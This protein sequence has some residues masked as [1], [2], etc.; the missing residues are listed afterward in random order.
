MGNSIKHIFQD[1]KINQDTSFKSRLALLLFRLV[2]ATKSLPIYLSWITLLFR[3]IYQLFVEWVLGI[4][5]PWDTQVGE[6]LKLHHGVALVVNHKTIIG[7]NCV[8]RH[9]TTIGNKKLSDGSASASPN[10]GNNVDIGSNV[11]IIGPI[12]V[13]NNSVI[14]AGSVVIKD[15]PPNTV[16]VGNPARVVRTLE[17]VHSPSVS[18]E[19][20]N[21]LELESASGRSVTNDSQ[22]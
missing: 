19:E 1:W 3:G 5:L 22:S 12:S 10:I 21:V 13:G 16:V 18:S 14:G 6:N 7:D 4:E 11:V 20:L 8:L 17:S 2:Q 15:V 9:S